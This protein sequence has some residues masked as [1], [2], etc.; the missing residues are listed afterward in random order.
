MFIVNCLR[1][2]ADL[3]TETQNED[4]IFDFETPNKQYYD[5]VLGARVQ[6][7]RKVDVIQSLGRTK[8]LIKG[9]ASSLREKA[10]VENKSSGL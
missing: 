2:H 10:L 4:E 6:K 5:R 3:E 9:I 7:Q 1:L 8:E